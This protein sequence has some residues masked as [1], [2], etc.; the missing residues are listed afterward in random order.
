MARDEHRTPS[1]EET[2]EWMERQFS[3][4]AP[5]PERRAHRLVPSRS[6]LGIASLA[7]GAVLM[8]TLALEPIPFCFI[9]LLFVALALIL[10]FPKF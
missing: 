5:P 3:R 2:I 6:Q 4:G 1:E 10:L 8:V 7:V 9:G